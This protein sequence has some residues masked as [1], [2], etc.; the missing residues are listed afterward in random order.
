MDQMELAVNA[1]RAGGKDTNVPTMPG[2]QP[3]TL[4]Q[5]RGGWIRE[6]AKEN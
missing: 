6:S 1:L 4:E 2:R 3:F 5:L